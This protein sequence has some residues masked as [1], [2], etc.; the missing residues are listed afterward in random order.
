MYINIDVNGNE[1]IKVGILTTL[2]LIDPTQLTW[3]GKHPTN[4]TW[5]HCLSLLWL[6]K[7]KTVYRLIYSSVKVMNMPIVAK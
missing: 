1:I 5:C 6:S 4:Y 2:N 3:I 7:R